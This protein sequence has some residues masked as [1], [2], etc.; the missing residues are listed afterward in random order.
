MLISFTGKLGSG[1]SVIAKHLE[2]HY[3]FTVVSF[4]GPLKEIVKSFSP[5]GKIDKVRDRRIL[6][7]L[8]TTY[9]RT[10]DP[11][12]WAKLFRANVEK[13]GGD[14]VNDDCRF[15]NERDIVR[16]MGGH[17]VYVFSSPQQC[18]ERQAKRD[19]KR[20]AGIEG[21]PSE[22]ICAPNDPSVSYILD[23]QGPEEWIPDRVKEMLSSLQ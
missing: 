5:D 6:Q 10:I 16:A 22:Q 7:E 12:Y 21:H 11:D 9:F 13:I 23:N 3:G 20:E 4:A 2:A 19:G 18:A 8:G 14:V 1:K 15:P 17:V